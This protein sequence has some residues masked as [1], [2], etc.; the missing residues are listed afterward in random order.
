MS[1]VAL[2]IEDP[3]CGA[4]VMLELRYL[5]TDT[6]GPIFERLRAKL[7]GIAAHTGMEKVFHLRGADVYHVERL[8]LMDIRCG[9]PSL[10]SRCGQPT[11][12][13][14]RSRDAALDDTARPLRNPSGPRRD[15]ARG[16]LR[17]QLG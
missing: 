5:R 9:L 3:T 11:T 16:R 17:R 8:E 15:A 13:A 14:R 10:A 12:S 7:A 1:R 6:E 2:S 4:G